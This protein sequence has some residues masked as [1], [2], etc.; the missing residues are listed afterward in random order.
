MANEQLRW[1]LQF[2]GGEVSIYLPSRL[3]VADIV[4]LKDQF[5][6][7]LKL[8]ARNPLPATDIAHG[9]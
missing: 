2:D 9:K 6:L 8:M 5:D 1:Q 3:T 7:I 4:D